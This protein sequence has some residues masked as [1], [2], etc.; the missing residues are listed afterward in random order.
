[1]IDIKSKVEIFTNP[2]KIVDYAKEKWKKRNFVILIVVGGLLTGFNFFLTNFLVMVTASTF[3]WI[4]LMLSFGII[5]LLSF[6]AYYLGLIWLVTWIYLKASGVKGGNIS[7]NPEK[8]EEN[9]IVLVKNDIRKRLKIFSYCFLVPFL[10]Y[11][12]IQAVLTVFFLRLH[13][14]AA[15]VYKD[16]GKFLLYA[17][18]LSLSLYSTQDIDKSQKYKLNIVVLSSFLVAYLIL[19]LITFYGTILIINIIL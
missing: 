1:M 18:I 11:N 13:W 5:L 6:V 7:P 12:L 19:Y 16:Y 10:I 4:L 9:A 8:K 14:T 15:L 2:N 3:V 17:W